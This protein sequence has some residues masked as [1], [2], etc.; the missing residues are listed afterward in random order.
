[1]IEESGPYDNSARLSGSV[2]LASSQSFKFHLT[3]R[4]N[5]YLY[6]IAPGDNNKPT[7]FLTAEPDKDTGV[8]TN[9]VEEGVDFSFPKDDTGKENWITLDKNPGTETYTIIF[10]PTQLTAPA[11]FNKKAGHTLSADE[12]REL[13]D[14]R[15]KY[16]ANA[17]V[18]AV[19]N[20][21]GTEPLV[22]VKT[23]QAA[24]TSEPVIFDVRIEHK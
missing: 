12:Q 15:A 7:T 20:G 16:K 21:G 11:F 24:S 2:L 3:P 6:I 23:P 14:F 10:S 9:E 5:G 4:A 18:T 19:I 22:S 17:P 8:E 1:V 13:D